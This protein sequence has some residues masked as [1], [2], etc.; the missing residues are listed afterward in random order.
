[1]IQHLNILYNG[2]YTVYYPS[3]HIVSSISLVMKNFKI[4]S[5][6]NLQKYSIT[7]YMLVH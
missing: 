5:L 6:S 2:H 4:C 1:M 7:N 3:P